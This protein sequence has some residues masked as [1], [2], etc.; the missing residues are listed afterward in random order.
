M[1]FTPSHM[2]AALPFVRTPLP[3]AAVAIG[4]MAPDVPYYVPL[5]L[6]R[7]FTHS[8][9]GI[10]TAD[11]AITLVLTLLWYAV[12]RTPIVDLSPGVVRG[13]MPGL[14]PLGWRAP[15]R[16]WPASLLL[17]ICGSL[18]GILTH[19]TWDAF[20][21]RGWL[22]D[23]VPAL[24]AQIGPLALFS[25]LQHGSTV[26]GL[27]FL[28][29]YAVRWVRRTPADP[30]RTSWAGDRDRMIVWLCMSGAFA[31]TGLVVWAIFISSGMPP[32]DPPVVFNVATNAGAAAGLVGFTICAA[33]WTGRASRARQ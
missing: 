11:L 32:F 17:L 26:A 1:P 28:A 23:V 14:G 9:P 18:A 2:A 25:W 31:G 3:I 27:G 4:S 29:V 33:W 12:L 30:D 20:T 5:G 13:R 15:E 19:L 10:P 24:T 21:H 22:S 7:D 6:P 8:L 16:G